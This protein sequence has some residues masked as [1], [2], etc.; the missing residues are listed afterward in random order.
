[1]KFLIFILLASLT[2]GQRNADGAKK[3]YVFIFYP[4]DVA[5]PYPAILFYHDVNADSIFG[6]DIIIRRIEVSETELTSIENTVQQP[7]IT[8]TTD[9][10]HALIAVCTFTNENDRCRYLKDDL[11]IKE[12]FN[13][14]SQQ[15]TDSIKQESSVK[16]LNS[17]LGRLGLP[18]IISKG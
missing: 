11:V 15:F 4:G 3:G 10:T 14:I 9:T 6:N 18:R 16:A 8:Y 2:V 5:K 1:M 7:K 12:L 17:L 13:Q